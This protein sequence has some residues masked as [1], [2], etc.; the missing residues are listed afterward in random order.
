MTRGT[1]LY[2][3]ALPEDLVREVKAIAARRGMTLTALVTEELRRLV[4][5]E[6]SPGDHPVEEVSKGDLHEADRELE[7]N[8][9]WFAANR[10][11]LLRRY[12]DQY[13]AIY[14]KRVID[15][16]HD[17]DALARRVFARLG[18]VPVCM[19]KV[20]SQERIVHIPSPRLAEA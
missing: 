9:R 8:M 14:R 17:F 11:R 13:I 4:E 10:S 5:R 3:R 7:E 1:T 18:T 20:T 6:H 12:R 16:D 2:L 15:H 19:P